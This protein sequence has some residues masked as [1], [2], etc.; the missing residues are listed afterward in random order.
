MAQCEAPHHAGVEPIPEVWL[1]LA[2]TVSLAADTGEAALHV[3]HDLER[4]LN[5][6]T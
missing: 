3:W 1:H 6:R 2:P 5:R 4:R